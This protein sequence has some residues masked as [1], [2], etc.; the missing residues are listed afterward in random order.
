MSRMKLM[1]KQKLL[2]VNLVFSIII[3][4][5]FFIFVPKYL[6]KVYAKNIEILVKPISVLQIDADGIIRSTQLIDRAQFIEQFTKNILLLNQCEVKL[7]SNKKIVINDYYLGIEKKDIELLQINLKQNG[8]DCGHN[9]Q[10]IVHKTQLEIIDVYRQ[11]IQFL[12]KDGRF[13]IRD[14]NR[15]IFLDGQ[16][17]SISKDIQKYS[18]Y[19]ES[20]A[21][22]YFGKYGLTFFTFIISM[23]LMTCFTLYKNSL[24]K[25]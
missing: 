15:F 2:I 23:L 4:I 25:T 14:L 17:I 7:I 11:K 19:S 10:G 8:R 9:L 13:I 1:Y 3:S 20:G 16:L 24:K 6:D 22:S 18:S 5:T 21:Q 12:L